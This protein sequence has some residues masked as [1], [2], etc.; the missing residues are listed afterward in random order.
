MHSLGRPSPARPHRQLRQFVGERIRAAI[1]EGKVP[2]GTWLR[3]EALAKELGVSHMPV[4]EALRELA[5][6]GLVEHVPYCGMRVASFP[7][8]DLEDLYA[9]RALLEG[10]AA[11]AAAQRITGAEL[12]ALRRLLDGMKRKLGPKQLAQYRALNHRFHEA[13]FHASGR[14]FLVKMLEQIWATFPTMLF[15]HVALAA[16]V[17]LPARDAI[18][19]SEHEEILAA[20]ERHDPAAAERAVRRHIANA[21]RA[22]VAAL[23]NGG[24]IPQRTA[25]SRPPRARTRRNR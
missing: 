7:I 24:A 21:G 3:Q 13:V 23:R 19:V 25:A 16:H 8:E 11:R 12:A 18:D 14:R 4:R 9:C 22:L 1:L 2:A 5:S 6:E 10:M 17:P 20:L 15:S